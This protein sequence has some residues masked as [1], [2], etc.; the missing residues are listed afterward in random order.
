MTRHELRTADETSALGEAGRHY[1]N[2]REM[3]V[4]VL[5]VGFFLDDGM[6]KLGWTGSDWIGLDYLL[7]TWVRRRGFMWFLLFVFI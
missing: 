4:C 5:Y 1:L 3:C 2:V 6:G 7:H